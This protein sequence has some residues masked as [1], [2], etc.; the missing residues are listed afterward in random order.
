MKNVFTNESI[1]AFLPKIM[2]RQEIE[3]QILAY[4]C[5]NNSTCR[6]IL[7]NSS[8]F[9][10]AVEEAYNKQIEMKELAKQKIIEQLEA[11]KN[12]TRELVEYILT[13]IPI[14]RAMIENIHWLVALTASA[15]IIIYGKIILGPIFVLLSILSYRLISKKDSWEELVEFIQMK[16]GKI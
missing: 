7:Q 1:E 15:V 13:K 12:K 2:S 3:E 16:S 5:G 14:T 6:A 11:Q 10:Q 9:H 8:Q 4:N